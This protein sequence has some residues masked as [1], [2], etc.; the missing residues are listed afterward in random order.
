MTELTA[1]QPPLVG[2]PARVALSGCSSIR[3]WM[4][5]LAWAQMR[6]TCCTSSVE[7]LRGAEQAADRFAALL[8]G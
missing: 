3:T 4:A 8:G 1:L 7:A 2:P 5:C 6:D